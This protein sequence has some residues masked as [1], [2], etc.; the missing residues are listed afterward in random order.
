M[1][2]VSLEIEGFKRFGSRTKMNV[3]GRVVAI[4]G[5]NEAGKTSILRALDSLSTTAAF[6]DNEFSRGVDVPGAEMVAAR[7]LIEDADRA[8]IGKFPGITDLRW[9]VYSKE[10]DGSLVHRIE[11]ENCL[12]RD[13]KKRT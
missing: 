10:P 1:R 8:E 7:F 5:P 12:T 13:L 4:V 9:Y 6:R 2:M 3:S 11:P